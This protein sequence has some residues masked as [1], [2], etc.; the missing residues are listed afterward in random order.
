MAGKGILGGK[1]MLKRDLEKILKFGGKNLAGTYPSPQAK[2][3]RRQK[4]KK[5]MTADADDGGTVD[6]RT[7]PPHILP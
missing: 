6:I 3:K 1:V 2:Q 5:I 7:I 4:T